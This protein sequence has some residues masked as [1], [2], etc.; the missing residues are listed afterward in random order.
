MK[1]VFLSEVGEQFEHE[2]GSSGRRDSVFPGLESKLKVAIADL[3]AAKQALSTP[4]GNSF[5]DKRRFF[6]AKSNP[7]ASN[8]KIN[9]LELKVATRRAWLTRQGATVDSD[10]N[11]DWSK[12]Q[13]V[14]EY[15]DNSLKQSHTML[16]F[17]GGR[18]FLDDACTQPFDTRNMVTQFSGPGKAIYVMGRTG[19][20]HVSSHAVGYRHHS[21]LLAGTNVAGAGELEAHNGKLTWL[22][23]KSG[24][25]APSVIHLIQVLHQLQKKNVPMDFQLTVLPDND[26]YPNVQTFLAKLEMLGEADYDLSKLMQYRFDD[27]LL[28]QNG[29]RW[30]THDHEQPGV[31]TISSGQPVP[32]KVVRQW[33]K[34]RGRRPEMSIQAGAS[35]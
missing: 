7:A 31:Y 19:N 16:R 12:S 9:E 32:H 21:S 10:G 25:Y 18:I 1:Y 30:R 8:G 5:Q 20:I 6:E 17:A 3:R 33:L 11:I 28:A 22:S 27:D 14:V 15:D 26:R 13:R 24:H 34:A 29:W 2:K 23:N 35:R 4:T